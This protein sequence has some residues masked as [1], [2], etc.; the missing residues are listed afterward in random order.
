VT[1]LENDDISSI[2]QAVDYNICDH[3]VSEIV[4][5]LE[6]CNILTIV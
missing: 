4:D 5:I 6:I 3:A 2:K 1:N